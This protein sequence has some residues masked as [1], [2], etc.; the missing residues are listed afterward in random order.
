MVLTRRGGS[1]LVAAAGLWSVG[2]FFGVAELYVVAV[3][4]AALVGAGALAVRLSAGTISVR[5]GVSNDRILH[6]GT[7]T[8][9]LQLRNDGHGLGRVG[10]SVLLVEDAVPRRLGTDARFVVPGLG[11]RRT[12]RLDYAL[13]GG[14]RGRYHIGPARVRVRDPFGL[15]QR[16]RRYASTDEVLV[17]PRVE[18]LPAIG[19]LGAHHGD[20]SSSERRLF[21]TGDEFYTM[22]EYVMGDD[23]RQVHWP[24]TAHRQTLMV[25]Q[26]EQPW[27][28]KATVFLDTRQLAH[29]D[30][31]PGSG[32][33]KAVSAAAS[34]VWHLADER[35]G[36][37]LVTDTDTIPHTTRAEPWQSCLDRL[38]ELT[39]SRLASPGAAL[40]R[41]RAGA[42]GVLIA[43]IAP[44]AGDQ[45][46]VRHPDLAALLTAGRSFVSRIAIVVGPPGGRGLARA[47]TTTALLRASGW[48]ATMVR[49]DQPLAPQWA[50]LASRRV[51]L[52]PAAAPGHASSTFG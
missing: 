22:R 3:A 31:G 34:V 40:Q 45:P 44:P 42:E 49:A 19:S 27:Q 16:V 38:A 7:V 13:T 51:A 36:L 33:E 2:R 23:L 25:R 14:A 20:G 6:G 9:T 46:P 52:R 15:A 5:R 30:V 18:R 10:S 4:A 11:P 24:S 21:T 39:P 32:F 12:V 1:L 48:R 17:Y 43:V 41:L 29:R 8:A 26:Q 37:R 35:Y 50:A 28:P 47:E